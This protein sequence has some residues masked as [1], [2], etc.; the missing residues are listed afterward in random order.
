ML[1]PLIDTGATETVLTLTYL[2]WVLEDKATD[3]AKK[4]LVYRVLKASDFIAHLT[5]QWLHR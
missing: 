4:L 2:H 1:Q 3:G 5:E